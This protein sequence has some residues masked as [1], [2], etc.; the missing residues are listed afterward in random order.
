MATKTPPRE[1]T[2]EEVIKR[3][4]ASGEMKLIEVLYDRYSDKVYR[5]CLSFVKQPNIAEDITHDIF[6]KVYM[7]LSSYKSKSRFST[8]LYSITYNYCID[9]LRKGKKEKVVPLENQVKSIQELED[10]G[11]DELPYIEIE[12]L[13]VIMEKINSEEKMI[14]LMKYKEGMSI[15]EIKDVF[16][17]S[18]S[19]TKMR[20][21]RAKEKV[22][23][24]YFETY[25]ENL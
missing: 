5:K 14:L 16:E 21:K 8:W 13:K 19:A 20:I 25:K 22:R 17:I 6:I 11:I 24:F 3:I 12:R 4:L 15:K 10:D 18:E 1:L 9:Y 7:N 23:S 2:D